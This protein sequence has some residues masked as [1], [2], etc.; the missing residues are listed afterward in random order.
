[1]NETTKEISNQFISLTSSK[2]IIYLQG[3]DSRDLLN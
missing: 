3:G 2:S 1:M